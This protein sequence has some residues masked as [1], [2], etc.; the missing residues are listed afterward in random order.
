M[1]YMRL[2]YLVFDKFGLLNIRR[3]LLVLENSNI[4]IG[5]MLVLCVKNILKYKFYMNYYKQFIEFY[6]RKCKFFLGWFNEFIYEYDNFVQLV[7]CDFMLFFK[8][9]KDLGKL[10]NF[11]LIVMSDYGI[12]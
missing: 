10:D 9:M 8:W 4:N 7:D 2:F 5:S 12:M 1:Y 6:G 3:V 11:V